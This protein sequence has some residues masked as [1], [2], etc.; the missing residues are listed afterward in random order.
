[1]KNQYFDSVFL[2]GVNKH[3]SD[4]NGV[5]QTA[6]LMG[7]DGNKKLLKDLGLY[8]PGM[9]AAQAND[10]IVSIS[11]DSESITSK[12]L[13]RLPEYLKGGV[14]AIGKTR[15]STLENGL[16]MKPDANLAVISIPGE[17]AAREAKKALDH[18][19]N[20]FLFSDNV[21]LEDELM[22][23]SYAAKQGLLVMGPDCGTSLIGGKGIGFANAVRKGSIGA[24]GPSGTGLQEFTSQVHNAGYGI[25]HAIG[26]GSHD[27]SDTIGGL[28]TLSA[29]DALESDPGT[30]VIAIISKP[31]GEKTLVK[32]MD[33]LKNCPKPIVGC[34]LGAQSISPT[35]CSMFSRATTIDEAVR[36]SIDNSGGKVETESLEN[37]IFAK[38]V[39]RE[40]QGFST[41]QKYLRGIFAGGTFCYQSQQIL[42]AHG[43]PV[44]SNA[45]LDK[46]MLLDHPTHSREHSM[47]DMGDDYFTQ[48]KPHPMID[49][50]E[51]KRRILEEARDPE[52]KILLLDFILGYNASMDPAGELAD[53][54][55]EA[56][57][58][59]AARQGY[60]SIV[61]SICGTEED[62]QD[63]KLQEKILEE[64]GVIV[65]RSNAKASQFCVELLK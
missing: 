46:K 50:T 48:G 1:M 63:L 27:L 14:E 58:I 61:T 26:T 31:P 13:A 55:A 56:K 35:G 18:G 45:P 16:T 36:L 7:S 59:V 28:T 4:E 30:K 25:S 49:G 60:L 21:N 24:I 29:L 22:L 57:K 52:L 65:F 51:R 12:L 39:N 15:L 10:L 11:A 34:F 40:K 8:D 5:Q 43:F 3:L 6:V 38:M 37:E 53:A 17:F 19:L 64:L 47:V 54:I 44:Y 41:K 23:K 62:P 9:D 32:L 20:V 33:R 2:M 42:L